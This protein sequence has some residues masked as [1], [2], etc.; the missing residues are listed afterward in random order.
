LF[1]IVT[2]ILP[3]GLVGLFNRAKKKPAAPAQADTKASA[4]ESAKE[5][6]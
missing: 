6:V 4:P 1:V 3:K 2:L 5:T